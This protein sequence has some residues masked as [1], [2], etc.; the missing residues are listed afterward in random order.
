MEK[1]NQNNVDFLREHSNSLVLISKDKTVLDSLKSEKDIEIY[2]IDDMESLNG[3]GIYNELIKKLNKTFV[4]VNSSFEE[5]KF[6]RFVVNRTLNVFE[7]EKIF[8][9]IIVYPKYDFPRK[10]TLK[11]ISLIKLFNRSNIELDIVDSVYYVGQYGT[12]GY[13]TAAKGYVAEYVTKGVP[14][15]W[16]ALRFDSSKLDTTNYVNAL[17]ES[18]MNRSL[19][20]KD[21]ITLHSTPDLW[22]EF[23]RKYEC[24]KYKRVVGYCA[25]ESSKLPPKWVDCV[26]MLPE[27]WVPSSYNKEVY[28]KCGVKSKVEVVPHVWFDQKL[29]EKRKINITDCFGTELSKTKYTF[30]SIGEL[31]ARKSIEE[32]VKVFDRLNDN[33]PNTQLLLKVH[34]KDYT[35]NNINYIVNK[36]SVLTDKIGKSIHLLLMNLNEREMLSL[37]SFGD[38]YVSLT[39]SEGFGLTI[40]EAFHLKKDVIAT[41]YSGHIDF[42]GKDHPG[43]IK[44]KIG[45]IQGM[46]TFS[47]NYTSDQEWAYPDLDHTYALMESKLK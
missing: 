31:T 40:F 37:H 16:H 11:K 35:L 20:G 27:V 43:L 6:L 14:V 29:L 25:W 44:Y 26:N 8:C 1:Y 42:L 3:I 5:N 15:C 23:I 47:S 36:L 2:L 4:F 10:E 21:Q 7:K 24:S 38:C 12:S 9:N 33:Y 34:Y 41:G 32:L 45:S 19:M 18:A 13:A 39:K 46:E 30:Y 17:A 22:P 28:E